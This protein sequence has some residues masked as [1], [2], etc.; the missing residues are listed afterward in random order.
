M[1][2]RQLKHLAHLD[3]FAAFIAEQWPSEPGALGWRVGEQK[4]WWQRFW[5]LFWRSHV[6]RRRTRAEGFHL[7]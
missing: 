6:V 2:V 3:K 4:Q 1:V 5:R 7:P